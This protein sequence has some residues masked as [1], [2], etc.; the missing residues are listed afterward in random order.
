MIQQILLVIDPEVHAHPLSLGFIW[1]FCVEDFEGLCLSVADENIWF[2]IYYNIYT[3]SNKKKMLPV[4]ENA[5][6]LPTEEVILFSSEKCAVS[7]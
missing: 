4:R 6:N 5:E 7:L 1:T 3:A 2:E